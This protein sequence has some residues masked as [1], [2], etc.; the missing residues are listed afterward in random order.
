MDKK[1]DISVKGLPLEV[2]KAL[3]SKAGAEDKSMNKLIIEILTE[4]VK[5][6]GDQ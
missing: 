2:K 3:R 5:K 6:G 4:W 1:V